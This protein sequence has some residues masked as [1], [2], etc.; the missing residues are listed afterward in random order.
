M[1]YF[2]EKTSLIFLISAISLSSE[3]AERDAV[4]LEQGSKTPYA[5]VLF[6]TD[7]ANELRKMVVELETARALNESYEKSIQAYAKN[8][9]LIETKTNT[10]LEQNDKL[11]LAL[12]RSRD[13][14]DFQKVLWFSLGILATGFALYG[15]KALTQ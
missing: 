3:A 4:F 5:G 14:N 10:L 6:P 8:I 15:A 9:Q 1:R 11:A 7:K 13:T 12:T 2:R